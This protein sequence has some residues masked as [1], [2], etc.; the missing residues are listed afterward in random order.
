MQD[1][2]QCRTAISYLQDVWLHGNQ[3]TME[4]SKGGNIPPIPPSRF[5]IVE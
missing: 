3:L 1:M 2:Q 5:E 4:M